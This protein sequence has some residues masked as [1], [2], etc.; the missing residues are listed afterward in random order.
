M[1]LTAVIPTPWA[2]KRECELPANSHFKLI[3]NP[4]MNSTWM[5]FVDK[6]RTGEPLPRNWKLMHTQ[7]STMTLGSPRHAKRSQG[8]PKETK[9]YPNEN[10]WGPEETNEG[11][12]ETN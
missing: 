6:L 1:C 10:K 11:H 8:Y 3:A 2:R 12:R 9:G 7:E 5:T 4:G